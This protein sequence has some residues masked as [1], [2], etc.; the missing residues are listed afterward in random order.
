MHQKDDLIDIE[1]QSVGKDLRMLAEAIPCRKTFRTELRKNLTV[2]ART[3]DAEK[4]VRTLGATSQGT[5]GAKA[6]PSRSRPRTYLQCLSQGVGSIGRFF[7]RRLATKNALVLAGIVVLVIVISTAALVPSVRAQLGKIIA[8]PARFRFL[9]WTRSGTVSGTVT[10]ALSAPEEFTEFT[11]LHPTYLP[12]GLSSW[13][14]FRTH[15]SDEPEPEFLEMTYNSVNQFLI[16]TQSKATA[17]RALPAGRDVTVTGQPAVLVTGLEGTFTGDRNTSRIWIYYG[18]NAREETSGT[19]F[20][21]VQPSIDHRV[22][23]DYTNGKQLTWYAD[24]VKVVM[25]SNLSEKEMLKIAESLAPVEQA[26][27]DLRWRLSP[28]PRLSV[29]LLPIES[30]P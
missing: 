4:E 6:H 18:G 7:E 23:I 22:S 12:A 29:E 14:S 16:I 20:L 1:R 10:V 28:P 25:L 9:F 24:D 26:G 2:Q 27:G 11:P 3:L 13:P 21:S 5:G 15:T 17:D 30:D 8:D 19:L